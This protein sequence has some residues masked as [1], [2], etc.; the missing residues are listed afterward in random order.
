MFY[1]TENATYVQRT[2]FT[3]GPVSLI[4][5]MMALAPDKKFNDQDNEFLI[6]HEAN[7]MFMGKGHPGCSCYGLAL[8]AMKRGFSKTEI[9]INSKND[10]Y[11]FDDW[12]EDSPE[13]EKEAYHVIEKKFLSSFIEANG[14]CVES[15]EISFNS[16]LQKLKDGYLGVGLISF[17]DTR[18]EGHWVA[19]LDTIGDDAIVYFDPWRKLGFQIT[20]EK[21]FHEVFVYGKN[22]KQAMI[23]IKN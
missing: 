4:N 2:E 21:D 20:T 23:F 5:V 18:I 19:L 22:D 15:A 16:V 10:D 11:L 17:S 14:S 1:K 3:C 8:S 9:F 6:W 7:T 12:L 13:F